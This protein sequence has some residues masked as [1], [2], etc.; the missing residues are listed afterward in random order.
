MNSHL[1]QELLNELGSSL[2]SLETRNTAL[3]QFLN[4]RGNRYRRPTCS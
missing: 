3:L 1:A 2:E 4:D